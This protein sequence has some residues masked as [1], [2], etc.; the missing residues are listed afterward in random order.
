MLGINTPG[1]KYPRPYRNYAAV[2]PGDPK[3]L[4]LA[5]I[6]AIEFS[7]RRFEL[8]YFR[9]TDAGKEAAIKSHKSIRYGRARRVYLRFLDVRDCDCDLSFK[10]FLTNPDYKEARR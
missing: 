6:G 7:G 1:D 3:Y 5:A 8:D 10:E 4:A 9:C 2:N